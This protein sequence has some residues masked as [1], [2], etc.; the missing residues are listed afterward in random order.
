MRPLLKVIEGVVNDP[1]LSW[2]EKGKTVF[3]IL[4]YGKPEGFTIDL[5][6]RRWGEE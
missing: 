4:N 1:L 3:E 5:F 2:E 6:P